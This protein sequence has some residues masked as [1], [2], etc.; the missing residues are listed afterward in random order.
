MRRFYLKLSRGRSHLSSSRI[1]AG[2]V[3]AEQRHSCASHTHT[4]SHTHLGTDT[5]SCS[6]QRAEVASPERWVWPLPKSAL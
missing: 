6:S 5:H 4:P 1:L 2:S 3:S